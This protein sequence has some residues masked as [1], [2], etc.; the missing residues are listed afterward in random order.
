MRKQ[1]KDRRDVSRSYSRGRLETQT[2]AVFLPWLALHSRGS[3]FCTTICI[4][5][6][7]SPAWLRGMLPD[8][9]AAIFFFLVIAWQNIVI[10]Q[11]ERGDVGNRALS[12]CSSRPTSPSLMLPWQT[13]LATWL[14]QPL[15]L[16]SGSLWG[17][18]VPRTPRRTRLWLLGTEGDPDFVL[19]EI[20]GHSIF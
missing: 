5:S 3:T 20:S 2:A 16:V 7:V 8:S 12:S 13:A 15:F 6:W 19:L 18:V 9:S 17:N 1:S 10:Y 11:R 4:L 14:L